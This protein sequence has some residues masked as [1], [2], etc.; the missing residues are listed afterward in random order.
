[1]G[2]HHDILM[3]NFFAQTEAL[4][5]GKGETEVRAEMGANVEE[6]VV[7]HKVLHDFLY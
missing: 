1:M 6:G 2:E 7:P 3:S 5:W 4:G